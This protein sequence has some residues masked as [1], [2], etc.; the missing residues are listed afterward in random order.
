[1]M[2]RIEAASSLRKHPTFVTRGVLP[3]RVSDTVASMISHLL[4]MVP[5][6]ARSGVAIIIRRSK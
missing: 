5:L 2:V 3:P 4:G 6:A 1:M